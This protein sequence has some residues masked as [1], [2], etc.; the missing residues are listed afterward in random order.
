MSESSQSKRLVLIVFLSEPISVKNACLW[1][2]VRLYFAGTPL[3]TMILSTGCCHLAG[4]NRPPEQGEVGT[5]DEPER[6]QR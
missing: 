1:I 6:P 3:V 4:M 5:Y 2:D